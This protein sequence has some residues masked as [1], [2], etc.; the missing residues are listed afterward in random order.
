MKRIAVIMGGPSSEHEI[1]L[2]SGKKVMSALAD[3]EPIE[4]VVSKQGVWSIGGEKAASLGAA[5]DR[6]AS[7]ADVCFLALHGQFGEDGTIQGLLEVAGLPYTG[8]GVMAS[9]L[10][11]DK[12][13]TKLVYRDRGIPTPEFEPVTRA[14]WA[15]E[16]SAVVS[17]VTSR[18]GYPCVVKPGR[19]GSSVGVS[20]PKDTAS[21]E[22]SLDVLMESN[23]LGLV[24]TCVKG[25]EFTCGILQ[26]DRERKTMALPVTEIIPDA[27]YAYFD[28]EAKYTPGA[29]REITPADLPRPVFEKIQQLALSAHRWLDCRDFSRTDV[30]LDAGGQPFV[31]ETNTIPGLTPTSLLPQAA[32]V[33]GYD[34]RA[35]VDIL[36]DNALAR[37]P[38]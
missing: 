28:Y 18:L 35:L 25:R 4:V 6:L 32:E 11:M 13:R 20:F 27:R 15:E 31:L 38:R 14:R 30:M 17:A 26:I 29:T 24:E 37:A 33:A 8:S 5:I 1:S 12:V 3:R 16:R 9:A 34:Y 10:A 23:T 36:I 21:L 2:S 7:S 22:K 19:A